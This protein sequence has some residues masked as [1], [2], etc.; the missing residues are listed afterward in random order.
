MEPLLQIAE[1][2]ERRDERAAEALSEVERLQS[3]LDEVRTHAGAAAEFLRSFPDA[4]AALEDEERAATEARASAESG[5]AD[6]EA[7]L[8][9]ARDDAARLAAE[10]HVQ[11]ARDRVREAELWG[12]R[13][14]RDRVRL[15]H[16][17]E[18]RQH[19]A[20]RLEARA[21]EL[22]EQP[23]LARAVAPPAGGLHG[24]LDWGSRA[25]GELLVAHAGLAT[26]RDKVVREAS[27]L[28][29]SVLGEPLT[30]TGV[31]G[32]RERLERALAGDS[33]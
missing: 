7:E 19:E 6:A 30:A 1:D 32:V 10:R 22:A 14:R 17:K 28:M 33:P 31:E 8:E 3:D 11:Q 13:S 27:E 23:V 21:H 29:A 25:R 18:D 15:E 26:E 20:V 16:E 24:V 2:L 12:E 9:R 5:V 4:L